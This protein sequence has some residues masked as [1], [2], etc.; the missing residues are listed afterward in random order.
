M[1]VYSALVEY[2]FGF[3]AG[4]GFVA[5][6]FRDVLFQLAFCQD[7]AKQAEWVAAKKAILLVEAVLTPSS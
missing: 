1:R 2:A 7:A 4:P 5:R 6:V 3:V